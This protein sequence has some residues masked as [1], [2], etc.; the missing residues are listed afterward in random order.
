MK[1]GESGRL[2]Q[3]KMSMAAERSQSWKASWPAGIGGNGIMGPRS[4][5]KSSD[6][7]GRFLRVPGVVL[8]K[9]TMA[10][11]LGRIGRGDYFVLTADYT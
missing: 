5:I 4:T 3:P 2:P 8:V 6:N 7:G 1:I 9:S 10:G 11:G